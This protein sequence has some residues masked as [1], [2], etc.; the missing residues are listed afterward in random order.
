MG[1]Q[2]A[3]MK[4]QGQ[5]VNKFL[6]VFPMKKY[7][8]EVSFATEKR[9][10]V[11]A[12]TSEEAVRKVAEK[13][14]KGYENGDKMSDI[15]FVFIESTEKLPD[16]STRSVK[17]SLSKVNDFKCDNIEIRTCEASDTDDIDDIVLDDC[18]LCPH[19]STCQCYSE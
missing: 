6:E 9:V 17:T 18:E 12:D 1:V 16:G 5:L 4:L 11:D 3:T 2:I 7:E 14:T 19:K 13:F 10:S 8:I 15:V